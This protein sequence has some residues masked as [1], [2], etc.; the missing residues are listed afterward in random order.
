MTGQFPTPILDRE[1]PLPRPPRIRID[2][3]ITSV[4]V[5]FFG[6]TIA[7]WALLAFGVPTVFSD[8]MRAAIDLLRGDWP[9]SRVVWTIAA[10]WVA[11][12]ATIAVH[13]L[14]HVLG[15]KAAGFAYHSVRIGP[16]QFDKR[17]ALTMSWKTE[18]MLTGMTFTVPVTTHALGRRAF[19]MVAGGPLASVLS[20]ALIY[21]L[22]F[23]KG[24]FWS[25]FLVASTLNGLA[26][27]VPMRSAIGW[28]DGKI[29]ANLV[30]SS[31]WGERW[32]ALIRLR[33]D[34]LN[35]TPLENLSPDFLAK[36]V[37]I[38]DPSPDTVTAHSF[39]YANAYHR[40][41][42]ERA[43]QMLEVCLAH[44]HHAAPA[45]RDM[46]ISDVAVFQA[47]KRNQP[48]L[49]RQW[50]QSLGPATATWNRLRVEASILEAEGDLAAT[51]AKLSECEAAAK[52][53]PDPQQRTWVL[54]IIERWQ[55]RLGAQA[56]ST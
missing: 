50:L 56:P 43:A 6:A 29:L 2:A 13:E 46:L 31:A 33:V 1:A 55:S 7:V 12:L 39:A 18:S 23:P 26:E 8:W 53:L 35:Q 38:C 25:V 21:A 44:I 54:G 45:I 32:L 3:S 28:S 48:E 52:A 30:L 37:A 17:L 16:F 19:V 27:L 40:N 5:L 14:G 34:V 49:A 20:A 9:P 11:L 24:I 15:G 47:E 41:E 10:T 4:A 51:A 22:P 42:L 36:A